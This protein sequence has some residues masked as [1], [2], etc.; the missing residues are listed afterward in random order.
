M[1]CWL[2][3]TYRM[4]EL[5]SP[6]CF[7]LDFTRQPRKSGCLPK[8]AVCELWQWGQRH[9][10]DSRESEKPGMQNIWGKPQGMSTKPVREKSWE[11][12]PPRTLQGQAVHSIWSLHLTKTCPEELDL[13]LQD[14]MLALLGFSFALVPR[15]FPVL[16]FE[17][18]MFTLCHL[19]CVLT[20][21]KFVHGLPAKVCF[22]F[23]EDFVLG[24]F[25]NAENCE[26]FGNSYT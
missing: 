13:K 18:W 21:K 20:S 2:L 22:C 26:D 17:I 9:C 7:G 11:V 5:Q 10:G 4:Q 16:P 3:Q 14:L 6:G 15:Y 1:R 25:S 19:C 24:L 12:Q 23:W 8:R